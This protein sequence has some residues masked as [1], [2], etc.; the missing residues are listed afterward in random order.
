MALKFDIEDAGGPK[1]TVRQR[2]YV[3]EDG[4]LVGEG[5]QERK[6]LW[7]AAGQEILRSE[8]DKR[9]LLTEPEPEPELEP[10]SSQTARKSTGSQK[11][12]RK[13]TARKQTGR[14]S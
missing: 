14:G 13:Q 1:V 10:G 4:R 11:R 6:W 8:A 5:A 9:G 12:T 7:C 2:L 3:T